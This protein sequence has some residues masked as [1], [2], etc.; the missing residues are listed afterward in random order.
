ALGRDPAN[1][2]VEL[3]KFAP[4]VVMNNALRGKP[5]AKIPA[6]HDQTFANLQSAFAKT[7]P[8]P[9]PVQSFRGLNF[10]NGVELNK[11]LKHV[12]DNRSNVDL[13]PVKGLVPVGTAN[14]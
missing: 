4:Y 6:P 5:P 12:Q 14:I 3:K 2:K 9:E 7:K 8:F 10:T 1:P 13:I 11:F